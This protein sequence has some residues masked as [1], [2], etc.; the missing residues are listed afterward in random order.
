M[1]SHHHNLRIKEQSADHVLCRPTRQDA[2]EAV[3]TLIAYAGENPNREALLD[4]PRRVVDAHEYFF[5]GYTVDTDNLLS[6][7]F[8]ASGYQDFI[9]LEAISFVSYCE[10]HLL[11]FEGKVHIAYFPFD[12]RIVGLSKLARLVDVLSRRMQ[13]QERLTVEIAET[14]QKGLNS[15][16]VAVMVQ[17]THQCIAHRGVCKDNVLTRTS[18]FLGAFEADHSL[19]D[20]WIQL[21]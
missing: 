4:T 15:P 2:E 1:D 13:V 16:G 6:K 3:R 5:S 14:I 17:A 19:R 7:T 20:R 11:P 10:H 9:S 12:N 18:H 8:S 21:I